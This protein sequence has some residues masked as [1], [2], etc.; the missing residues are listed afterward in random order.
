MSSL[1]LSMS[2]CTAKSPEVTP[3]R[4]TPLLFAE[5]TLIAVFTAAIWQFTR[6]HR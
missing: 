2:V 6:G 4:L 1:T 3:A 5:E